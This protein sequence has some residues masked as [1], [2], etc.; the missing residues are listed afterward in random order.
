MCVIPMMES[1]ESNALT[2]RWKIGPSLYTAYPK[3]REETEDSSETGLGSGSRANTVVVARTSLILV[4][5]CLN[6]DRLHCIA[7]IQQC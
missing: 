3:N 2:G 1:K 5:S 4:Q 7:S 6:E